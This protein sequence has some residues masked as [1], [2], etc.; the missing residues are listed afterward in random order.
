MGSTGSENT[1]QAAGRGR[2][3]RLVRP[4][5]VRRR[6]SAQRQRDPPAADDDR[7]GRA[8][9]RGELNLGLIG[10]PRDKATNGWDPHFG[11]GRVNLAGGDEARSAT[12]TSRR[13]AQIDSPAWFAPINVD[14]GPPGASPSRAASPRRTGAAS[15]HWELEYA[16]GQD[17]PDA[18]LRRRR[19]ARAPAPGRRRTAHPRHDPEGHARDLAAQLQ[20]RG[21]E[22]RRA[23]RRAAP[24]T[25]GRPIPI[26]N[27]DPE[28]HAFQIRLTVEEAGNPDNFG[29]YRK[30]LFAYE[31]DGNLAGWPKPSAPAAEPADYVTGSG[32]EVS[33]RLYDVDGDNELDVVQADHQRRALRPARRRHAGAEL[34]RR[35]AR[36]HRPATR[37]RRT[38]RSGPACRPRASRR[39][40]RRSATSTATSRQRSCSTRASTS[41][42]GSSTATRPGFAGFP[43][44]RR[45][46]ATSRSRAS[47]ASAEALLRPGRPARSPASNH[48]K[49][50]FLGSPALAD[51]DCDGGLDIVAGGAR[52]APLRLGRRAA[53]R[54]RASRASS[55]SAGADGA[56]IVTSPA[57]AELD[58]NGWTR[59]RRRRLARDRHR[60]QRGGRRRPGVP[61]RPDAI[62][63]LFNV[64]IGAPPA[65]T[66]STRSTATA[67]R[68]RAGRSRSAS[69]P[70]T[71]C[72]SC[73]RVTTPRS[74]DVDGSTAATRRGLGLRRDLGAAGRAP[75]S[76]TATAP[77]SAPTS[78]PSPTAPTRAR[79]STSP[80]TPRSGTSSAPGA[81][82][83]SRAGSPSTA[84]PTCSR[85]TRTFRSATSS[86]PGTPPPA[87]A[88]PGLPVA[89][90]DFQ[91]LS[92]GLDR[93][94][95][96]HRPGPPGARR[97]RPLPP[98][99]VRH[100]RRRAGRVAEVHRRLDAGDAGGRRRRRRRRP[101]RHQVTREG[102][103]F[104]WDTDSAASA[105]GTDD[106]VDACDGSNEEWWT[107]HHDERSTGN[108]GTDGR[109]P[110]CPRPRSSRRRC[111][112]RSRPHATS[113]TT[114]QLGFIAP[115]DD[116]LCGTA[117]E[118]RVIVSPDPIDGRPT[119]PSSTTS[120]Q[121]PRARPR[122]F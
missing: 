26:P 117:E 34:Q 94:G 114:W 83:R 73:C 30:T 47:P 63:Q 1:G 42:P 71:C 104:L 16:C 31:D 43:V 50:G 36:H 57:I 12:T 41:T 6:Q 78:P 85:S 7:R 45:S 110:G 54:C 96:R 61:G 105:D 14:R 13:E 82:G 107:F 53:S 19:A 106:G 108:Y 49:R 95:R 56:E 69:P 38:T 86:R 109:P 102:W 66:R 118:F 97:D 72:R 91:L 116:W 122:A 68:C 8:T 48:I 81:L 89:T 5:Q 70:A 113:T 44:T 4:A 76:S 90:D 22:R 67:P 92:P 32:G 120:V 39:E 62:F 52:P 119:A 93:A 33:P 25:A 101:R 24:P 27:P 100:R 10:A 40:C 65:P 59:R 77:R 88:L 84:P 11:Y 29:R 112:A 51:L 121:R 23:A 79:C 87:R 111:P 55:Q 17:A 103:S 15:A 99:R 3:D 98:P 74:L 20:R 115:G 18:E 9:G 64:L 80:T 58:G 28:R 2:P 46:T 21:R 75:G 37:S 60:D 35:P